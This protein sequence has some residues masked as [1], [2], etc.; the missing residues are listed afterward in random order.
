MM[1]ASP[2]GKSP[3]CMTLSPANIYRTRETPAN[4]FYSGV[5][6]AKGYKGNANLPI[7]A[8]E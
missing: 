1:K 5:I 3:R 4:R 7:S 2:N 8:K 6:R